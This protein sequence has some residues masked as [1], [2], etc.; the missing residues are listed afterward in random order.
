MLKY[1]SLIK[2]P[3]NLFNKYVVWKLKKLSKEFMNILHTFSNKLPRNV[4]SAQRL[5]R[6]GVSVINSGRVSPSDVQSY[7]VACRVTWRVYLAPN[8]PKRYSTKC[9]R[10]GTDVAKQLSGAC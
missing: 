7:S 1:I 10:A 3:M 8:S 2:S 5:G 6:R 9:G 4:F